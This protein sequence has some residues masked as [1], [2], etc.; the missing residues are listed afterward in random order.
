MDIV[1]NINPPTT[2]AQSA[3]RIF[4]SRDGRLFIGKNRQK[5]RFAREWNTLE[6]L[7]AIRTPTQPFVGALSISVRLVYPWRSG[8]SKKT[9]SLGMIP[10]ST[11]PDLDNLAKYLLDLMQKNGYYS[12]DS[13][14]CEL[15][16][17]KF[18]GEN[19]CVKISLK[20]FEKTVDN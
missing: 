7:L 14:V 11:K 16:L 6:H 2:T 13:Q 15:K 1:L 17:T 5:G 12:N 20:N 18:W 8:E 4:K 10:K 9:R 3:A 19:P